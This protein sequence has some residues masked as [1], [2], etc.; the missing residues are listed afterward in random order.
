MFF[1]DVKLNETWNVASDF[2]IRQAEALD[3][4]RQTLARTSL[5]YTI[6]PGLKIGAGYAYVN[7]T[8]YDLL[9]EPD[10][11]ENRIFQQLE[12]KWTLGEPVGLSH[13][14]R[15]EQRF[16]EQNGA[17]NF[18]NRLRYRISGRYPKASEPGLYL[19]MNNEFFVDYARGTWATLAQNRFYSALGLPVGEARKVRAEVGYLWQA[20]RRESRASLNVH[21]LQLG[22]QFDL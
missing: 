18:A 6:A 11:S 1:P 13:R 7:S 4:N 19:S 8:D 21:A 5:N 15:V 20:V 10:N 17:S 12:Y 3:Q 14:V 22:F 16:I 2:Q 9:I